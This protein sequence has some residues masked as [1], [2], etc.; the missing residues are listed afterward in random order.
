MNGQG[1]TTLYRVQTDGSYG[2]K[3]G[4]RIAAILYHTDHTPGPRTMIHVTAS[5]STETEWASVA[6][7][8]A[9]AI[10]HKKAHVALENDNLGVMRSLI[11]Y[12]SFQS[13]HDYD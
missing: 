6:L 1:P 11:F 7:G 9:L 8:L 2:S 3:K 10:Q 4:G 5:S 12:R 13:R